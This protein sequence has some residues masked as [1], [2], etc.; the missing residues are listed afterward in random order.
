LREQ[1]DELH[2]Q[3]LTLHVSSA[4]DRPASLAAQTGA[5]AFNQA[6]ASW[7]NG[8]AGELGGR[9]AKAFG[10]VHDLTSRMGYFSPSSF[11]S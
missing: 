2:G 3:S 8:D 11:R 5:A 9:L 6:F 4:T 1:G 7:L 10:E